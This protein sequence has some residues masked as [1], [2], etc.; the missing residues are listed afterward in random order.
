[1]R[2]NLRIKED[3][4]NFTK[5]LF[6]ALF[7]EEKHQQQELDALE[8]IFKNVVSEITTNK[9]DDLWQAFREKLPEIKRSIE[10]DA[11]ATEKNDPACKGLHEVYL[12]YPGFHAIAIHRMSHELFRLGLPIVARMMSECI[13]G[14]TGIDIHPGATIGTSFFI[15]HGT[16]I[17]IGETTIIKNNVKIYQGVTLGGLSVKKSLSQ[18][19]RHPTIEDN[20]TIY[21][22]ATI[23]GGD[24]VIGA[25]SI[26]GANV[27]ITKSVPPNALVTYQSEIKISTR[28]HD[29]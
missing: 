3:V 28:K 18:T 26:I 12:A 23:L 5:R 22:N 8:H 13:H 7:D 21:A 2:I 14:K 20:V 25:N 1:M 16:G 4:A 11:L 19:K 17:V 29:K 6:Y 27:W 10:L 9:P 15:D 24:I